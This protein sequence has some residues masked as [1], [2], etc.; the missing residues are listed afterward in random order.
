MSKNELRARDYLEHIQQAIERV[1]RYVENTSEIDFLQNE[2]IQDAAIRN[3]EVIGEAAN[4]ILKNAPDFASQHSDVP[5]AVMYAMRNRVSHGYHKVDFEIV[6]KTI[7][8]DLPL[9]H[10]QVTALLKQLDNS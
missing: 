1:H 2:L 6:W 8:S 7:H 5:F 3:I 9:I 4:N 10:R